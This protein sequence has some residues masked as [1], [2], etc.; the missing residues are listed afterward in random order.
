MQASTSM[1]TC[2][3]PFSH[4]CDFHG[5][6]VPVEEVFHRFLALGEA[7]QAREGREWLAHCSKQVH[8]CF[9]GATAQEKLRASK[10]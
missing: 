10:A 9:Q 2:P 3:T 6:L 1:P 5:Q 8:G 7:A 4:L